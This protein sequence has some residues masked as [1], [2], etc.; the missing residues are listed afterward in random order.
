[1]NKDRY[2]ALRL[3]L[4][5]KGLLPSLCFLF[6]PKLEK[7]V[8]FSSEFN[9]TY[10]HNSKYLFEYF[11]NKHPEK[12]IKFVIND[13]ILREDLSATVGDY[14]VESETL[15]GM[16]YVLRAK[17]W[18]VSS[19]ETPVGGMFLS[20]GR[21][22]Y[23]LGHGAPIKSIGLLEKYS[24]LKKK[25]Y[26]KLIRFNFSYFFSTSELFRSTWSGF[27][28]VKP[29][30]VVIMGQAR[31]DI[32]HEPNQS[33][34]KKLISKSSS[35]K[36]VLYAPTWRAF[37][38]TKL[39][40]FACIDLFRLSNFLE[41]NNINIFL[42]LHPN[43]EES[44]PKEMTDIARVTTLF[45]SE[46][47]DINDILGAFDLLIT[48]YSSIYIDYLVTH[49]PILFLPYDYEEFKEE[50]GFTISYMEYAPGPKPKTQVEFESELKK[51]L[52]NSHYYKE[53]RIFAN[54]ILNDLERG[55]C[56]QNA[57]FILKKLK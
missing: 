56:E 43:F 19:L 32:L 5:L 57:D 36:N 42:R 15:A 23:H 17:T 45:S 49:K 47:A 1:M 48:D 34:V 44:T 22:V 27:I 21:Y 28:G 4:F 53:E 9:V 20:A 33:L 10:K 24:N 13:Q 7:R 54:N 11:I 38:D 55:N 40:P 39:F 12:E 31:N 6:I 2:V 26:L 52:F 30:K 8:I 35:C 29:N 18:I 14:F 25:T 50:I 3:K 41:E 46:V 16:I 37:C 51:L